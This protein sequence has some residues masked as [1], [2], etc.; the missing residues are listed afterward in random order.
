[1][2]L[3]R[4]AEIERLG[5]NE[6]WSS[7][8]R[9]AL[10]YGNA[11]HAPRPPPW[12][13]RCLRATGWRKCCFNVFLLVP[14]SLMISSMVSLLCSRACSMIRSD[15][16]SSSAR[17]SFSAR[18]FSPAAAFV[19]AKR[20]GRTSPRAASLASLTGSSLG[21]GDERSN[22]LLCSVR[23]RFRASCTARKNSPRR[24][25]GESFQE[26][27]SEGRNRTQK[28]SREKER[29]SRTSEACGKK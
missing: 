25:A 21:S 23:S 17:T 13:A 27:S 29:R 8:S 9:Q 3:V 1:V 24:G 12:S 7:A 5:L 11:Y 18:L 2:Q 16:S 28:L 19:V 22:T 20:E 10:S 15:S 4:D 26:T 6:L 14:V